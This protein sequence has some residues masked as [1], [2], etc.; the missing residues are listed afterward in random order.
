MVVI[1]NRGDRFN[2]IAMMVKGRNILHF[3][4]LMP[5]NLADKWLA[6]WHLLKTCTWTC[7]AEPALE[8]KQGFKPR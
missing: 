5:N 7:T 2:D 3:L 6:T 8:L 4:H 1:L